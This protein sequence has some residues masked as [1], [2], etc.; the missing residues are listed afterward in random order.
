ML[1]SP[2]EYVRPSSVAEAL[3]LLE[4]HDGARALA[5]GQTLVNVMKT[6]MVAPDVLVDLGGLDELREVSPTSDGG[7][8][9][10]AVVTYSALM[11]SAEVGATRPILAEVAAQI[12][13]VQVRNRG[14]IGGNICANDPTNHFPPLLVALAAAM[15]IAGKAGERQVPAEEFFVGVYLTAVG[16]GELLTKVTVPPNGGAGDAFA[17][18]TIGRDGTGIVNVA[19]TVQA[20]GTVEDARIAAGCAAAVPARAAEMETRLRG[21]VVD[22][23]AVSAAAQGLGAALDPPSDVHGSADY[24]RHLAEILAVRAVLQ[25]AERAGD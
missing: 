21:G 9:V 18:V 25:A 22:E 6:R 17:S 10:G 23:A 14:T 20:N 5:G 12:A 2:V 8:E 3:R 11:S 13:D 16:P 15:T 4:Q 7:R 19:A 24:R 1:L